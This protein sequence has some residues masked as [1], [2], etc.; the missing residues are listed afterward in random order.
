MDSPAHR[1]GTCEKSLMA[2]T[3]NCKSLCQ[4]A[5]KG[6]KHKTEGGACT[7][8]DDFASPGRKLPADGHSSVTTRTERKQTHGGVWC[9]GHRCNVKSTLYRHKYDHAT[10][11]SSKKG[12]S[13]HHRKGEGSCELRQM[14]QTSSSRYSHVKRRDKFKGSSWYDQNGKGKCLKTESHSRHVEGCNRKYRTDLDRKCQL[15]IQDSKWYKH[16]RRGKNNKEKNIA[17]TGTTEGEISCK[18]RRSEVRKKNVHQS[19]SHKRGNFSK[20]PEERNEG[21]EGSEQKGN[22]VTPPNQPGSSSSGV[23][24]IP[25]FY[26]D[27]EKKRY[28]RILPGQFHNNSW[29]TSKTIQEKK[30]DDTRR[31][32]FKQENQPKHNCQ[33]ST[34]A[35]AVSILQSLQR[36]ELSTVKYFRSSIECRIRAMNLHPLADYE[37]STEFLF[38]GIQ[39]QTKFLQVDRSQSKLLLVLESES[40]SRVLFGSVSVAKKDSSKELQLNGWR[41]FLARGGSHYQISSASFVNISQQDSSPAEN[42][43]ALYSWSGDFGSGVHLVRCPS[44]GFGVSRIGYRFD[45]PG[46]IIRSCSGCSN[47]QYPAYLCVGFSNKAELI[48]TQS[49]SRQIL[50]T[51]KREVYSQVFAREQPLIYLGTKRGHIMTYDLR[52]HPSSFLMSFEESSNSLSSLYHGKGVCSLRLLKDESYLLAGSFNGLIRLWDLRKRAVVKEIYGHENTYKQLPVEMDESESLVYAV[53]QD[54]LTR[55]WSLK[56]CSHLKTIPYPYPLR[57]CPP[58]SA[59]SLNWGGK[60]LPGLMTGANGK[61]YWYPF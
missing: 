47:P 12:R 17:I 29:I 43:Y 34:S 3:E 25:G 27:Q 40:M 9:D 18:N 55:I 57:N 38:S 30:E 28:F 26:Y 15:N 14:S 11:T 20:F 52:I 48:D 42:L 61:L 60:G 16:R 41:D 2:G 24:Q 35:S 31:K 8:S 19:K 32:L 46:E 49:T 1:S 21:Q 23:R 53:G 54:K 10:G 44:D 5:K 33:K 45:G 6:K 7:S 59:M 4:V 13:L 51:K 36:G 58:V 50:D 37:P 56:D 22:S 39:F